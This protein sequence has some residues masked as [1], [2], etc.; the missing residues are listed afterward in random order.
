MRQCSYSSSYS[1]VIRHPVW[2]LPP[3][4]VEWRH[5]LLCCYSVEVVAGCLLCV[6]LCFLSYRPVSLI[7]VQMI[8]VLFFRFC[9]SFFLIHLFLFS[10]F[11]L[12][13]IV[14]CAGLHVFCFLRAC[15]LR[16]ASHS[17]ITLLCFHC[18]SDVPRSLRPRGSSI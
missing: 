8:F 11:S 13:Q 14:W 16:L 12:L 17:Q 4:L 3:M 9:F 7:F 15:S 18:V 10:F 6:V 1:R 5:L 2:L